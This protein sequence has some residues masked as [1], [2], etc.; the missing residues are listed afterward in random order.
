MSPLFL[1][2]SLTTYLPTCLP[3]CLPAYL[4]TYLSLSLCLSP[5]SPSRRFSIDIRISILWGCLFH[6]R[7]KDYFKTLLA[8][9]HNPKTVDIRICH[10]KKGASKPICLCIEFLP[11]TEA[12]YL[13]NMF[14]PPLSAQANIPPISPMEVVR[15]LP[16]CC[17]RHLGKH[18]EE[19]LGRRCSI[20]IYTLAQVLE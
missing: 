20:Y 4:P 6:I 11:N 14:F 5:P 10:L 3:A 13:G 17:F 9:F 12:S 19:P 7:G 15:N 2:L 16:S 1:S 18:I 8:M